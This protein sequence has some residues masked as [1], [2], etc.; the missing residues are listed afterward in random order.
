MSKDASD[1]VKDTIERLKKQC[2]EPRN[3]GKQ[4][5]PRI[6]YIN[7]V[8]ARCVKFKSVFFLVGPTPEELEEM[9]Q[10]EAEAKKRKDEQE[11]TEREQKE[12]EEMAERKRRQDEWVFTFFGAFYRT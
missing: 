5:E 9:K 6:G 2:G 7:I 1:Y 12:R 4:Y 3:Y 8:W 10:Q 11:K